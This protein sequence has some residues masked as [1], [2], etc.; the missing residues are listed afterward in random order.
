MKMKQDHRLMSKDAIFRSIQNSKY[1]KLFHENPFEGMEK[2]IMALKDRFIQSIKPLD[3]SVEIEQTLQQSDL[4]Y[5]KLFDKFGYIPKDPDLVE[6]RVETPCSIVFTMIYNDLWGLANDHKS[7]SL[8]IYS[9]LK[10]YINKLLGKAV[11]A[12]STL[13]G[14]NCWVKIHTIATNYWD[15]RSEW[16]NKLNAQ[17]IENEVNT[18]IVVPN[19][20]LHTLAVHHRESGE[21]FTKWYQSTLDQLENKSAWKYVESATKMADYIHLIDSL[22]FNEELLLKLP[23]KYWLQWMDNLRLPILQAHVFY[24]IENLNELEYIIKYII[25]NSSVFKTKTEHLL[26]IALERYY[27]LLKKI[28]YHLYD[29]QDASW[30]DIDIV[31]KEKISTDVNQRLEAWKNNELKDSCQLV[32][33]TIF[34][35]APISESQYFNPIFEWLNSKSIY[36]YTRYYEPHK[37]LHQTIHEIFGNK[38]IQD[39]QNKIKI[40]KSIDI[41]VLNW[42][43]FNYLISMFDADTKDRVFQDALCQKYKGYIG[44]DRFSWNGEQE[45]RLEIIN[46]AVYFAYLISK[47]ANPLKEWADLFSKYKYR[48]EG[49]HFKY[50]NFSSRNRE[51]Y[52]LMVGFSLSQLLREDGKKAIEVLNNVLKKFILQSRMDTFLDVKQYQSILKFIVDTIACINLS[53]MNDYLADLLNKID[54]IEIIFIIMAQVVGLINQK[55]LQLEDSNVILIKHRITHEFW[56]IEN[57]YKDSTRRNQL[58]DYNK[59]KIKLLSIINN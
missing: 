7:T 4:F 46:Q 54:H 50:V 12:D 38:L 27:K 36:L 44:L 40:I 37:L 22:S 47:V 11:A 33:D 59:L 10:T 9:E 26:L 39:R 15:F 24:S 17:L 21:A 8:S 56:I 57:Q 20:P 6:L 18:L 45:Y 49:W 1:E 16:V 32:F 34:G 28:S 55:K 3:L 19:T 43:Y 2:L 58:D 42:Q 31:Q 25:D 13:Q 41:K 23:L 35:H 14:I 48:H 5:T 29:L 52:L 53:K 30:E 51:M